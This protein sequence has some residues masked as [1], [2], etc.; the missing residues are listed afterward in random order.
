MKKSLFSML[1]LFFIGL[2]SVLAQGREISGVVTSADDGLSIPGVSVIV[3][4]TTIGTTTDFDGNYSL[5]VPEGEKT[6]V[7]SF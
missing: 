6:L 4:G 1:I 2:Q 5:N 7:F 3:K